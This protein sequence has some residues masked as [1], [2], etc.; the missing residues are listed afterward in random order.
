[1][2]V[3]LARKINKIVRNNR[4]LMVRFSV[5]FAGSGKYGIFAGGKKRKPFGKPREFPVM[6]GCRKHSL[7]AIIYSL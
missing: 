5:I 7:P 3:V 4:L 1:M 2:N 6:T